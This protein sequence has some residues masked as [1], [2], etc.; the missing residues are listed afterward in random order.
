METP[1]EYYYTYYSYEEWGRGYFGSRKCYCLP[2]EDI[3]YLGSSKDKTFK[4]KYK[5][6]LKD[7][8]TTREEAYADEIILQQYYKVV[9]NPHFAN[10]AYQTSIKFY[11]ILP[12]DDKIK[13]GRKGGK[14]GGKR[15]AQTQRKNRTGIFGLTPEQLSENGK[16]SAL[17]A[18]ETGTG[19]YSISIKQRREN[20]KK[21]GYK[22]KENG[23]GLFALTKEQRSENGRKNGLKNHKEGKGCFSLTPEQRKEINKKTNSQK[24]RCL[25][26]GHISTPGALS[27]YQK[28]RGIDTSK[29]IRIE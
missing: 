13:N 11:C 8:Y 1:Q 6:I 21:S 5:I 7:D 18:K 24:W 22:H 25:V 14:V 28:A 27:N 15:G 4:P 10:K 20:G 12:K 9:E 16:K 29:R 23:T 17:L 26:T 2:E 19:L 3:K